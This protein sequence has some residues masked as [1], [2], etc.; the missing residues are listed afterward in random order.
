MKPLTVLLALVTVGGCSAPPREPA[1]PPPSFDALAK[2]AVSQYTGTLQISGLHAAVEV[3]RDEWGVPHIYAQNTEDLFMAEGFVVAQDRLWQMELAR[4]LAQGRLSELVGAAGVKHDRLYRLF[5]FRGPW[6]DTEWTNYHPEARIIFAAYARGINAF[7][8]QAGANLP[9]E[10]KLTGITPEPWKPEDLLIR[11]RVSAAVAEA[12]SELRLAQAVVT[13]GAVEANRRSRPEPYGDLVVPVAVD[14]TLITDD[15]AKALDG[16]EYGTFPK[17]HLLTAYRGLPGAKPSLDQGVPESAPGSNNFAIGGK[18]TA[19]GKAFM[20]DD[21]HRQVTSPALRYLVHLH[22][23]GWNIA[24]A[25]EPG[26]PGV[27]RGHNER[28]A[29]GRT[30]TGTDEAD[31]FVEH[32]NPA[33]PN[34]VMWNGKWEALQVATETIEVKGEQ[35]RTLAVKISRHGP[36]FYEDPAHHLAYALR[37]S[38]REPGTAEYLGGLRLDQ[39]TSARDC[40]TSSRFMRS[41]A[42]NLVCADA[43]GNIAFR[44]SAAVPQRSGWNGRLPVPGTGKYEWGG[45]RDDLPEAYNPPR[46]FIATANNNIHPPGYTPPLFYNNRGPYRRF[47]RLS[48]L[49][50]AG[51]HFSRD[52]VQ[53]IILDVHNTE[54]DELQRWFRGWTGT[55]GDL[56]RARALIAGWNGEM[57]KDSAAAALFVT[58]RARAALDELQAASPAKRQPLIE[59]GLTRASAALVSS[60]GADWSAWQW[61]R[62]NVSRFPHP[63]VSAFDIPAV[64][65]DGGAGTV[66]AIGSVYRMITDFSDLDRS[67]VTIGPGESGQ[68]GSPFYANLRESWGRREFWALPF[69]RAAVDAHAKFT[70]TLQPKR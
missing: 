16:D 6:D 39:A 33:D 19:T 21:P 7:I 17:P 42:T 56:E 57:R 18:A 12:R 43:D 29:W 68:P 37:A 36:I 14:L 63:L 61:G 58:W 47:D 60:Q 65:R 44:V 54:A 52:D 59:A 15:I 48:A 55:T 24:G 53:R 25:T 50:G 40:L 34:Q 35:P 27:I 32:V 5:K 3:I 8:A 26:L 30:A 20:V 45:F 38:M 23:P 31:V 66:N 11:N 28:V 67:L 22:A 64:E 41:P 46:G 10:F 62:I 9:V 4:A 49:L 70:L 69:T 13:Y 51:R 1:A 2:A